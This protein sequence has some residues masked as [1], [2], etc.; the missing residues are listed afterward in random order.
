[1]LQHNTLK[2]YKHQVT[3]LRQQVKTEKQQAAAQRML[4]TNWN[5]ELNERIAVLRGEKKTWTTEA[6]AMRAA[7]KE[8]KASI[9]ERYRSIS[10]HSHRPAQDTFAAQ[11]KLL[12]EATNAVFSLK[13]QI[14]E[15]APK[16]DRLHDYEIQIEQLMKLQRLWYVRLRFFRSCHAHCMLYRESDVQKLNDS[17]EYLAAFASKYKKMELSVEAHEKALLDMEEA[18]A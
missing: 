17:K 12:A 3:G 5:Q 13:T 9:L 8:A 16:V 7:E 4:Y 1:M 10:S 15:N 6:A 18:A 14:K 2:D 11:E